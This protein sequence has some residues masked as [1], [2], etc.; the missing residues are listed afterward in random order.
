MNDWKRLPLIAFMFMFFTRIREFI[1]PLFI[2]L[3][4][5][6]TNPTIVYTRW[7]FPLFIALLFIHSIFN[8]FFFRYRLDDDQLI[9]KK[10]IFIKKNRYIK[11]ER[12]QSVDMSANVL[13]RLFHLRK[14]SIE[15]AGGGME[16]EAEFVAMKKEEAEKIRAFFNE[17]KRKLAEE[18]EES[19][20][21]TWTYRVPMKNI[22]FAGLTSGK[23]GIVVSAVAAFLTQIDQFIPDEFYERTAG[24]MMAFGIVLIIF[25]VLVFLVI[26]WFVSI[27]ITVIKYGN[28]IITKRD[29]KVTITRGLLEQRELTLSLDRIT[30]VRYVTHPLRQMFGWW[31]IYVDSAGGG[32]AEEMLST[33]LFP[34]GSKQEAERLME[35]LLPDATI[36][37]NMVRLPKRARKRYIFRTSVVTFLFLPV[38]FWLPN[39]YFYLVVPILFMY[40]GYRRYEDARYEFLEDRAVFQMRNI[41]L[42][43]N[44]LP[45]RYMQSLSLSQT[46]FQKRKDLYTIETMILTSS[47]GRMFRLKDI[48]RIESKEPFQWYRKKQ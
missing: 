2:S 42:S 23:I 21:T 4:A 30:S 47:G 10:G 20:E 22:L 41:Q 5:G 44:V 19:N 37:E 40:L 28:F 15:T 8:W 25:L 14:L 6:G 31:S 46:I 18:V 39:G 12:V 16:A 29:N 7:L 3:F 27:F 17:G 32:K 34:L 43:I 11:K 38:V 45:R 36:P 9:V 24:M 26:A 1:V 33:L 48:E 35:H 13:H